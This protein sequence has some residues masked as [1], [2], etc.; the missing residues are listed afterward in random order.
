MGEI[1]LGRAGEGWNAGAMREDPAPAPRPD[2]EPAAGVRLPDGRS[3]RVHSRGAGTTLVLF[4][5]GLG[6]GGA[7]WGAV[8]EALPPGVRGLAYDRAGCGGSDP[9]PA[10]WAR[11]SPTCSRW[12]PPSRMSI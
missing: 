8:L 11:S 12:P 2:P 9:A 3:L 7:S 6:A 1:P 5:A 4:E 10:T